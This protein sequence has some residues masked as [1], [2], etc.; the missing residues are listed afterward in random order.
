M[1]PILLGLLAALAACAPATPPAAPSP[2]TVVDPAARAEQAALYALPLVIMDLT[3]EQ[4]FADPLGAEVTPDRFLHIPILGNPSFRTVVRP[5]VDTLYSTAWLDLS[6]EPVLLTVP[7]GD[8]RYYLIQCMD[9][10]TNVFA[11]PGIRTLG[12]RG[13]TYAI[14]GP[15]WHGPVPPQA[16]VVRAPTPMVWVLG[17]IYVRD[18]DDLAAA[19]AFQNRIDLRPAS[20][21]GD[22]AYQASMPRRRA[23]GTRPVMRDLLRGLGPAAFYERFARLAAANPP[24]PADPTF[25]RDVLAPLGLAP[26]APLTWPAL[27]AAARGAL[28]GALD[29]VLTTLSD[30][31]Q[32]RKASTVTPTGWSSL[33]PGLGQGS[34]GTGYAARAG[35]AMIG[36][37]ANLRI[38]AIYINAS[39]DAAGQPLDGSKRYRLRFTAGQAPPVHAFWSVTL[40]DE[41]GY[42]IAN[43]AERYAVKS[44]D[45]LAPEPDGALVIDLQPDD[46]GAARHA[47]WLPTPAGQR[48]ELSLRAYW[49]DD[50]LL[51]GHWTPPAVEPVP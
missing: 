7:P 6:A 13:A 25:V 11:A 10:W 21:A 37:G 24:S 1:R 51:Q 30:P 4:F 26:G 29:R 49:P 40:Y 3:R 16:E 35:V 9:A 8:G 14:V 17:R 42:L 47:N 45:P 28:A 39:V 22:A 18:P 2:T 48:F 15:D 44:G 12:N 31:A 46:P 43:P 36:L 50:A 27:D 34:Y 33:A 20:H 5:N 32:R 23:Q 41:Q 38:D 19:R